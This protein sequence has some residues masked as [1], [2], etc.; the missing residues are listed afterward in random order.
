MTHQKQHT[1]PIA[2]AAGM[3]R[4]Q[5]TFQGREMRLTHGSQTVRY[6]MITQFA[7]NAAKATLNQALLDQK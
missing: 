4:G 5:Y 7:L 3:T 6:A 1:S 2:V